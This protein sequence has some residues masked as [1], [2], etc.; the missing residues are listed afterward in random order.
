MRD[1]RW[2]FVVF[3]VLP[4]FN[5]CA[6]LVH[7]IFLATGARGATG[8][9]LVVVLVA[10]LLMLVALLHAGVRR[11]RDLAWSNT[12]T[13]VVFALAGL[14]VVPV[15]LLMAWLVFAPGQIDEPAP[16]AGLARWFSLVL[17]LGLPWMLILVA[18]AVG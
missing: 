14:L 6:L 5:L 2:Q 7:S 12:T 8:A 9:A 10:M 13:L 16:P 18:R 17:L 11:A 1:N 3:G 15:P 4:A